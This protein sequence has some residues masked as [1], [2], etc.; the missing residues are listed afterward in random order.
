[1]LPSKIQAQ[2]IHRLMNDSMDTM[3]SKYKE[4]R[5]KS[6]VFE[7]LACSLY[8]YDE[9]FDGLV[10]HQRS[11]IIEQLGI[12]AKEA[13]RT[14]NPLS[15]ELCVD[16]RED[17]K[18]AVRDVSRTI[19]HGRTDAIKAALSNIVALVKDLKQ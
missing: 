9:P 10:E 13:I 2:S 18:S 14:E 7:D 8:V 1:M 6:K 3:R 12:L 15:I 16:I 5:E 4:A 11:F 19:N 17:V